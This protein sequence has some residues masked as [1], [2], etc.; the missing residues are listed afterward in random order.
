MKTKLKEEIKVDFKTIKHFLKI[1]NNISKMY[2]PLLILSSIFKALTPLINIIMPK[3]IIDE[4]LGN[5][6]GEVFITLVLTIII[7]NALL[8]IINSIL[9]TKLSILKIQIVNGFE[10]LIGKKIMDMDFQN[11]EDPEILDLKERAIFPV[12][13]QGVIEDL[14]AVIVDI[15]TESIAIISILAVILTLDVYIILVI[16]AIVILNSYIYKK[17]QK[18]QFNIFQD[19]IPLNRA[20]GY[21]LSTTNDF[22]IAKDIR[23]YN[24]SP[25]I[26][27]KIKEYNKTTIKKFG[28]LS[29]AIGKYN[30]ISNINLQIQ[31]LAVYS[32]MTY[33]V[34]MNKIGIGSFAMYVSAASNFSSNISKFITN[35]IRIRQLCIYLNPYMEFEQIKSNQLSGDNKIDNIAQYEI[36]F[37]NVSFKY[38]RSNDYTLEDVSIKISAGEKLSV[39]GLN[40]AGKT[41]FIKLLTRLYRPSKGV[42]LLNGV[43][44]ENYDYDEYMKTLGVVF[45]DFKLFAFSIKENIILNDTKKFNKEKLYEAL[46]KSGL[47]K[48]VLKLDKGINTHIYKTFEE[49]GI[50]FSGGQAQ[51]LAISR[52]VYKDA[53]IVVLDEP[54]AA[55]DPIAEFEIYNSFNEL[56]GNK[57]A[58]YISH[59]LSS[60]KFCDK[61]AVFHKGRIIQYGTHEELI[62]EKE[63]QYNKMYMAQA[64]YYA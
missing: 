63:S 12:N 30:G 64:Q 10:L 59:R 29:N 15:F 53:P 17:I 28:N 62:K 50:E 36:E 56:I 42:I 13:N 4:L 1:T 14:I 18:M 2:I 7:S 35:F 32:Y 40:G 24:I 27:G 51:K 6:R 55:L 31:M 44:I 37:K 26:L 38:P 43:N 49:D 58:I 46:N 41:T 57:T 23:L 61:I 34:L 54:T 39:V 5:K 60:C 48:D 16:L 21:Y 45:Q 3:F 9:D 33:K 25:L 8:N 20:F 19:L 11:I 22:S 47:E 52:T